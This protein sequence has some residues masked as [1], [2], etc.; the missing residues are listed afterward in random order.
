[1]VSDEELKLE[2]IKKEN[3][4]ILKFWVVREVNKMMLA[5]LEKQMQ[6]VDDTI[7]FEIITFEDIDNIVNSVFCILNKNKK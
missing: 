4:R 5:C 1:M 3:E 7:E 6:L 2:K